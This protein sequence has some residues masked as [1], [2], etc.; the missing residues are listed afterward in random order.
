MTTEYFIRGIERFIEETALDAAQ[1][2]Y[3]KQAVVA[4]EEEAKKLKQPD[5]ENKLKYLWALPPAIILGSLLGSW[6]NRPQS[7]G[8][9][10]S[11]LRHMQD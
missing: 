8:N 5:K 9:A 11:F 7:S 3:F 6:L 1:A 4:K 2:E 10:S